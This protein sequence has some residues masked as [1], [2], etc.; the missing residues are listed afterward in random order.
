MY[1]VLY[2]YFFTISYL[3]N[4]IHNYVRQPH[5]QEYSLLL[6]S[7]P[8]NSLTN[9]VISIMIEV[10][11]KSMY[12][13]YVFVHKKLFLVTIWEFSR[14]G[15]VSVCSTVSF[16]L[17]MLPLCSL[18]YKSLPNSLKGLYKHSLPQFR[19]QEYVED[20]VDPAL[21]RYV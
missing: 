21:A 17:F 19:R 18:L 7:H 16:Q 13:Y 3:Y 8:Q 14:E 15:N 10:C 4:Y 9:T 1:N 2:V 5:A 20:A 12:N 11:N 6:Q